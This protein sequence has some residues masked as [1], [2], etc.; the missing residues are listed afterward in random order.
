[1][2]I[3]K[4]LSQK[5]REKIRNKNSNVL[6]ANEDAMDIVNTER[7]RRNRR[8]KKKAK[9]TIGVLLF[10]FLAIGGIYKNVTE[11]KAT[12]FASKVVNIGGPITLEGNYTVTVWRSGNTVYCKTHVYVAAPNGAWSAMGAQVSTNKGSASNTF[13]G[14]GSATPKAGS[15]D[16]QFSFNDAG[17][18]TISGTIYAG[19]TPNLN[20]SQALT[21]TFSVNYSSNTVAT[22]T[23]TYNTNGGYY[24]EPYKNSEGR[25]IIPDG[26]YTLQ[27]VWSKKNK[28]LN[29]YMTIKDGNMSSGTGMVITKNDPSSAQSQWTFERYKDTS[30]YYI[31][32]VK[33]GKAIGLNGYPQ[34]GSLRDKAVE[35]Y[36]QTLNEDD[37]LWYLREDGPGEYY[38]IN[39]HTRQGLTARYTTVGDG[40]GVFQYGEGNDTSENTIYGDSTWYFNKV[41]EEVRTKAYGATFFTKS[42]VPIRPGYTFKYWSSSKDFATTWDGKNWDFNSTILDRAYVR[43][44]GHN[45]Y[46]VLAH[47]NGSI[48][49]VSAPTWTMDGN[50]SDIVW[51]KLYPGTWERDGHTYNWGVQVTH[52]GEFAGTPLVTHF[53]SY[54]SNGSGQAAAREYGQVPR[55]FMSEGSYVFDQNGG[56]AT[57]YANWV[58]KT[59]KTTFHRNFNSNDTTTVT[60]TYT[61]GAGQ[62]FSTNGW[63]RQGYT[64]LGW[65]DSPNATTAKYTPTNGIGDDWIEAYSSSKDLYAVWKKNSYQQT[66]R[67]RFEN[68]DGSLGEYSQ[69]YQANHDYGSTFNWE[70]PASKQYQSAKVS[71]TVTGA[72]STDITVY[73]QKYALAI[74]GDDGVDSISGTGS[75]RYGSTVS[76]SYKVKTGYKFIKSTGT[77]SDGNQNGS[78]TGLAGKEGTIQDTWNIT[79]NRNIKIYTELINYSISYNLNGGSMSGQKTSYNVNTATFTLPMPSK[80]GYTFTGWT[81]SNGSATQKS[82][83]IA[84]GST[85]DKS[86]T[87]N[88]SANT[89]YVT[90]DA[91]GGSN[92]PAQQSFV[93][94]SG[95]KI[96]TTKPTRT[97]YTFINWVYG[98]TNFNPGD[99]IPS[100]W[101]SFTLKAQWKV[102]SYTITYKPNGGSGSEQTQTVTYG[103]AWTAKGAIYSRTGYTMSSW[104]TQANG[105]GTKYTLNLGQTDKQ[106][107]NVTLYA[108]WTPNTYTITSK[109]FYYYQNNTWKQFDIKTEQRT[110]GSSFAPHNVNSPTGYHAGNN[111]GYYTDKSEY[112]GGGTVGTNNITVNQNIIVHVYYYPNTYTITYKPN[113]GS[114]SDQTQT[115]TYGISW[116][117][118]DAIYSR[119]GYTQTSWNTQANGSGTKY[120]LNIGQTAEQLSDVTLYAQWTPNSYYLDLNGYLDGTS[121]GN[122]TGYG[123]ADVYVNGKLVADDVSD[124]CSQ[125]PYGSTYEIKDIKTKPGHVYNGVHSG[126]LSGTMGAGRASVELSFSTKVLT[127]TFHRNFNDSDAT[128][129]T[130]KFKYG[131]SGQAF[132]ANAWSRTGYTFLGWSA[133]KNATSMTW[134]D[135]CGVAD[136]WVDGNYPSINIYA[137]WALNTYSISY[138]LNGGSMSGQK[139]SYNINTETFTLPIPSK[140]GYAFTGWTGSNGTTPQ[141]S[142]SINKGSTGN[143]SYTANW[144]INN[145]TL[146]VNPNGGSWNGNSSS[147]NIAQNYNTTKAIPVPT[148]TGY[149]FLRWDLKGSG[150][151]NNRITS[152]PYFTSGMGGISTYNNNGDGKVSLTRQ[153]KSSD[154]TFG[155]NYEIK[156]DVKGANNPGYG[157]F[158]HGITSVANTKYVH[159]FI[160]KLPKGTTLAIAH[161]PVGDDYSKRWLTSNEG[162][163]KWELYAYEMNTGSKGTFS[164]F[165]HIYVSSS[166]TST[167]TWYLAA[168]QIT[169]VSSNATYTYGAGN[170]T[171]VAQ[172]APNRYTVTYNSNKGSGSMSPDTVTYNTAYKTKKNTFTRT[173]Y[174]FNGWNE[175][176]DGTGTAWSLASS[177]VY[178]ANKTWT[179]TY[180][181]DITLYAQWKA[182]SYTYNIKYVSSSGK[183]LGTD[184]VT[185]TFD[186]SKTVTPPAKTGYTT[187]AA[188]M[189]KFDSTSAKTITFTYPLINYTISYDVNGGTALS[190]Q[191]T[192][193]NIESS[194][195]TLPVPSRKGYTF[196]GWTGSNGTTPQKSVTIATSSTGNKSYKAN[197][198]VNTY[199]NSID[200]WAG[201]FKNQEGNN[202]SKSW[203][204]LRTTTFNKNYGETFSM[205]DS[206]AT[207]IPNGFY[208]INKF[209]TSSLEG[210]WKTYEKPYSIT[211]P[212]KDLYFEYDYYPYDYSIIYNL[213]GGTN[214]S[215]NPSKY[216]ILYGVSL[217]NPTKTGYTFLGWYDNTDLLAKVKYEINNDTTVNGNNYVFKNT[218]NGNTL[219]AF[220]IQTWKDGTYLE[221][222]AGGSQSGTR[223]EKYI[224]NRDTGNYTIRLKANGSTKDSSVYY[225]DVYL[226]KGKTYSISYNIEKCTSSEVVVK[227]FSFTRSDK[228]SGINEGANATFISSDELYAKLKNRQTG[229]INLTAKWTPNEYTLTL[230]PNGGN[231]KGNTNAQSLNPSL[232]YDRGNWWYVGSMTPSRVGYSFNGWFDAPSGGI[233]VYDSEGNCTNDGKYWKNKQ[234]KYL[235]NLTVYA[236]WTPNNYTYNIKY[237]SSSGKDLGHDTVTGAFDTS[238][239][240]TPPAKTGYTTPAAQTVKF[241][242]TSA[243]TITFTYQL[244]N[245][246]ISY[247]I[248]GGNAL[249]G[250][251]TSYNIESSTYTL[252]IPSR[253]GYKFTG[254]TGSNGTTPQ[255]SVTIATGSTGN[256]S[257]KAN[258]SANSLT[259]RYHS[260]GAFGGNKYENNSWK[261]D[262]VFDYG[263][264][265]DIVVYIQNLEEGSAANSGLQA[266]GVY[267]YSWKRKNDIYMYKNGY[268]GTGKYNTKPNGSGIEIDE[269]KTFNSVIELAN[270]LGV[271][272]DSKDNSID[273][274]PQWKAISYSIAYNGNGATSGSMSEQPATFDKNIELTPNSFSRKYTVTYN[275]MGGTV[276]AP[277][278]ITSATFNGWE[279]RGN[280]SFMDKNYA[281]NDF[282]APYY[283]QHYTDLNA[284]FGF[285]KYNLVK[286]YVQFGQSEGRNTKD[287]AGNAGLYPNEATVKNMTITNGYKVNLY[288]NWKLGAVTLPTPTR[289]GYKFLGWYTSAEGGTKITGATYTPTSNVTLYAHW[290]L[291]SYYIDYNVNDTGLTD[292]ITDNLSDNNG[293]LPGKDTAVMLTDFA[294]QNGSKYNTKYTF[295]EWNTKPDG[296]GKSFT[297]SITNDGSLCKPGETLTLYAQWDTTPTITGKNFYMLENMNSATDILISGKGLDKNPID[298]FPDN[299]KDVVYPVKGY[300]KNGTDISSKIKVDYVEFDNSKTAT[301]S[302]DT[303]KPGKYTVH[304][305]LTDGKQTKKFTRTITVLSASTPVIN[306][307][308]RYFNKGSFVTAEMLLST[309]TSGDR[310]DG[311]LTNKVAVLN[312]EQIAFNTVGSYELQYKVSNRSGKTVVKKVK[313]HILEYLTDNQA[314]K[315]NKY[316]YIRKDCSTKNDY[317]MEYFKEDSKWVTNN[318]LNN[319]II[320]SLSKDKSE[321]AIKKY[322]FGQDDIEKSKQ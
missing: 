301:A 219:N 71:Y 70:F 6:E 297:T 21:A 215:A 189:V 164:T 107:N 244:I 152:D 63:S 162:T 134:P 142:V 59:V 92:V 249:S 220:Q 154:N 117:S 296:S 119:T 239:T 197:W 210:T 156:I 87:A 166:S 86:Y 54:Y 181:H 18:G 115:A 193:Y 250:Q 36:N 276:N 169:T 118:K 307:G 291:D 122:I 168:S 147:Q 242:S 8:I 111:Y 320:D 293:S 201:G 305:S 129:T 91:N 259:V 251:R 26:N 39:K 304:Y 128:T 50:Q 94:N 88:W 262:I 77:T 106:L 290:K 216:N 279:D 217:K 84:K 130:Q 265:T 260:N 53:Y 319:Q 108:Q 49:E 46:E 90:Y 295:K 15:G 85:G 69:A 14:N 170:G 149:T 272:I 13:V 80:T 41:G 311:D 288:A 225:Y 139:T 318:E 269:N 58:P 223:Q 245:Y 184:T 264:S 132:N 206:L 44:I 252:P 228:V 104:N 187:P 10:C 97:G 12:N 126:K 163:G 125:I 25:I 322:H 180:T 205:N 35:M 183:V 47:T 241:D 284:A 51:Y 160:A 176:A 78:W 151:L 165:G 281:Y 101:G 233:K 182:N 112:L 5:L 237:V 298:H 4:K 96:S 76:V 312:M 275:A 273:L 299:M 236:Q 191:R 234:Y 29:Q 62:S 209:G 313:V 258:W 292:R 52:K 20:G 131:Q 277:N 28:N 136:S 227:N 289:F 283:S 221:T 213:D 285:N 68:A 229:N 138:N 148:R 211:Q 27:H 222:F 120:S 38:I 231:I 145:Y 16:I 167:F 11:V 22:H 105:S 247:D 161:N 246:T 33:S 174:T 158:Y 294:L 103:T 280:I 99:A 256:K 61:A 194:A 150:T 55:I 60:H 171:L 175:K 127:A 214:N 133:N 192:S 19:F 114:G 238:K 95:A 23:I 188:Q 254:W 89:Y 243:K 31:I 212:A 202:S 257:Y 124:Y 40:N 48:G 287:N 153:A 3:F 66:V 198:S 306:A 79:C 81:G 267:D 266:Y 253:K 137:V 116:T 155:S 30:Y 177:G 278:N 1:M 274:Y 200:H 113:G 7:Q 204:A 321:E 57:L 208:L 64:L 300:T 190:S 203:F 32:N 42:N 74:T 240:V 121:S 196:T 303:K 235:G 309:I 100:G 316:R 43:A 17:A 255:K 224:H 82:V 72:K 282:D 173:G 302:I 83:A 218:T 207:A 315:D 98:E 37:Y 123:T 271:S 263:Q 199:T 109:Y 270:Y 186:T 248:N 317:C 65:S 93:F 172:W 9:S 268:I 195:Y 24:K 232:Y 159:S 185:G 308:D 56:N 73:R 140:T 310:Y 157:G 135:K 144:S 286:H 45:K 75:F 146:T 179:W 314:D 110:Y 67:V 102:N 261:N 141:T 178:E 226:E 230:N 34:N 143:K 2:K